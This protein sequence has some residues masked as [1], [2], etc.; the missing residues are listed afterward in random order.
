MKQNT[1]EN[2]H[3]VDT[4]KPTILQ[5]SNVLVSIKIQNRTS[6]HAVYYLLGNRRIVVRH[7]IYNRTPKFKGA[8]KP[9]FHLTKTEEWG[10]IHLVRSP[11]EKTIS[12][13]LN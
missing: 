5:V 2:W 1:L 11:V 3:A 13:E 8:G 7:G 6:K 10:I 12:I 4:S 9:V